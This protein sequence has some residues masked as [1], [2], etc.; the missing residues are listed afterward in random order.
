MDKTMQ[1]Y[2]AVEAVEVVSR[3]SSN[4]IASPYE[5]MAP[6]MEHIK[7]EFRERLEPMA[8]QGLFAEGISLILREQGFGS[9]TEREHCGCSACAQRCSICEQKHHR[10]V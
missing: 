10:P 3:E 1:A 7:P 6:E 8:S 5:T 4:V 9:A 2:E